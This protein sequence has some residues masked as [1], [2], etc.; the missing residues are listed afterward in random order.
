[1]FLNCISGGRVEGAGQGLDNI[2]G[3]DPIQ[4]N[5]SSVTSC[6][7]SIIFRLPG[8]TN[9]RLVQMEVLMN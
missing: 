3:N 5:P 8:D 1:M 2:R 6:L 4:V 7:I 9:A